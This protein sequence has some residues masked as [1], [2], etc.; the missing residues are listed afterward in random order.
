MTYTRTLSDIADKNWLVWSK[1]DGPGRSLLGL[2]K[3][4]MVSFKNLYGERPEKM[5]LDFGQTEVLLNHS[6]LD[7]GGSVNPKSKKKKERTKEEKKI[8]KKSKR[9]S[10]KSKKSKGK[11]K[12][13]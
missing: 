3:L 6:V 7:K 5:L 13:R 12:V 10:N 2:A 9:V 1:E 8:I 11:R 4:A